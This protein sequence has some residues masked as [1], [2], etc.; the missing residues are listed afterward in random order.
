MVFKT[1]VADQSV[2]RRH[3]QLGEAQVLARLRWPVDRGVQRLR[4]QACQRRHPQRS[5]ARQRREPDIRRVLLV[6][7]AAPALDVAVRVG[8]VLFYDLPNDAGLAGARGPGQREKLRRRRGVVLQPLAD[9]VERN[10]LLRRRHELRPWL[11]VDRLRRRDVAR[12]RRW[13]RLRLWRRCVAQVLTL[14]EKTRPRRRQWRRGR[15]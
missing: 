9:G 3:A 7:V 12:S 10:S 15:C 6:A 14:S 13:F 4:R 1:L 8:L 11:V 2:H 5:L